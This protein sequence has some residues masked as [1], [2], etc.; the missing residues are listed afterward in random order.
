MSS[1]GPNM[2]P[3]SPLVFRMVMQTLRWSS[4]N[5]TEESRYG[6]WV[7]FIRKTIAINVDLYFETIFIWCT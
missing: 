3:F 5:P 6:L 4:E 1:L 2:I 7:L